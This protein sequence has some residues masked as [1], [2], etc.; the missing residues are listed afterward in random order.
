MR[1]TGT[2]APDG[3]SSAETKGIPVIGAVILLPE[4]S[5]P[6]PR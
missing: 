5:K 2:L 3:A 6:M 4:A 1:C